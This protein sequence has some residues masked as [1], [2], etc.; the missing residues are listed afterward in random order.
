M[1]LMSQFVK[2]VLQWSCE[3]GLLLNVANTKAIVIDSYYYI[4]ELSKHEIK[5]VTFNG[6]LTK[7]ESSVKSLGVI[8]N[9]KLD[10][11]QRVAAICKRS[12]SLMYH[13]NFFRKSTTFR[14]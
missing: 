7:L 9:C 10:W 4:N 11:K 5:G 14:L 3:N 1:T 13:L 6:S 2:L 12:D 8:I